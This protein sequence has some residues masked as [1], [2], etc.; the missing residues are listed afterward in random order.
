M[1]TKGEPHV[2]HEL[3]AY[4]EKVFPSRVSP[5]LVDDLRQYDYMAG[6]QHVIAK[7]RKLADSQRASTE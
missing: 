7:L 6:E 5:L 1:S 3:V 4:L 2:S